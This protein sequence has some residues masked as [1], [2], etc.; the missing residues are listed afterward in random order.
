MK[1]LKLLSAVALLTAVSSLA[2]SSS[3]LAAGRGPGPCTQ[4]GNHAVG[5]DGPAMSGG[6]LM[7]GVGQCRRVGSWDNARHYWRG[8]YGNGYGGGY[9]YDYGASGSGPMGYAPDY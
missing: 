4:P 7:A 9:G 5:A 2:T 6:Q 8:G 1:G 3:S